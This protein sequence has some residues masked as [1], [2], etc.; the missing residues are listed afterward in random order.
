[1][2]AR[3]GSKLMHSLLDSHE[4]ILSFPRTL[5]F[6]KFWKK[7]QHFQDDPQ[8]LVKNF[9]KTNQRFFPYHLTHNDPL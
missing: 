8:M 7:Y 1:M 9:I 4:N 2:I 6:K 5:N 3:C